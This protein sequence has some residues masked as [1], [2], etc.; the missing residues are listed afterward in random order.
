MSEHIAVP[1][2]FDNIGVLFI[3]G[4]ACFFIF[5]TLLIIRIYQR[6]KTKYF[7]IGLGMSVIAIIISVA[8]L[9]WLNQYTW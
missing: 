6:K 5:L 9:N 1:G 8:I 4:V 3:I 2:F 7:I